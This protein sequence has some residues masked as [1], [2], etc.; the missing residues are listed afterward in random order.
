MLPTEN[1]KDTRASMSATYRKNIAAEY[2]KLNARQSDI[3]LH[4]LQV[5]FNVIR[6]ALHPHVLVVVYI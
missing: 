3:L 2:T 5:L 1:F 6:P 4:L